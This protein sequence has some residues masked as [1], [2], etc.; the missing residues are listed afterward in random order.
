MDGDRSMSDISRLVD[1]IYNRLPLIA[2]H[3]MQGME[4]YVLR[5]TGELRESARV[6]VT[7]EG[8]TIEYGADY[9]EDVFNNPSIQN[10]T[11]PGTTSYWADAYIDT[12]LARD[13]DKAVAEIDA[14]LRGVTYDG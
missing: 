7:P 12:E 5:D 13:V 11:T 1:D 6:V 14:E 10:V 9:A 3:V 8:V 4:H 2:E